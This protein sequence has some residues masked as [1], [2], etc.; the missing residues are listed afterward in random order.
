MS[1]EWAENAQRI[2]R[3]DDGYLFEYLQALEIV[4]TGDDEVRFA[5]Q[6]AF[7]NSVVRFHGTRE[8]L[9]PDR[10]RN[11]LRDG[12]DQFEAGHYAG[13]VYVHLVS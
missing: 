9:Q 3:A 2:D 4:V 1:L 13:F 5:L 12:G 6:S 8:D 7:Q 11:D 10:R